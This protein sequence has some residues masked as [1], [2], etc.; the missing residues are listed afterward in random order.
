MRLY[1]IRVEKISSFLLNKHSVHSPITCNVLSSTSLTCSLK[2][3]IP[4]NC[5]HQSLDKHN[6]T[7]KIVFF[8]THQI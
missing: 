1:K 4:A 3:I 8:Q 5:I 6:L 2:C 7:H